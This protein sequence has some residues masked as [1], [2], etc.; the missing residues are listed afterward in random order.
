MSLISPIFLFLFLPLCIL[1]HVIFPRIQ[2]TYFLICFSFSIYLFASPE[3]FWILVAVCFVAWAS[4]SLKKQKILQRVDFICISTIL[5]ILFYYKYAVFAL[6]NLDEIWISVTGVSLSNSD[7]AI[8]ILLP[9]G[10]SFYSFQAISL[11]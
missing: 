11:I 2:R 8:A 5:I 9:A 6:E 1:G 10:I 4:V 7:Q 3:A